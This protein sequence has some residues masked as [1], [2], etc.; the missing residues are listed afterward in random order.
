M[1]VRCLRL[2]TRTIVNKLTSAKLIIFFVVK[3][4][5]SFLLLFLFKTQ[6]RCLQ[7][8]HRFNNCLQILPLSLIPFGPHAMYTLSVTLL[9]RFLLQQTMMAELEMCPWI[10]NLQNHFQQVN[11]ST[12]AKKST[13]FIFLNPF[14]SFFF[15]FSTSSTARYL[16]I[17]PS[18]LF[19]RPLCRKIF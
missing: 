6:A 7:T 18:W 19:F 17:S 13:I 8:H 4:Y 10:S 5:Q 3:L 16:H 1:P 9:L 2:E 12:I 14:L 11:P 15:P